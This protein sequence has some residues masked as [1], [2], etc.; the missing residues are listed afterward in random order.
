MNSFNNVSRVSF[1]VSVCLIFGYGLL[2]ATV[3]P[4][5]FGTQASESPLVTAP[6]DQPAIELA[7]QPGQPMADDRVDPRPMQ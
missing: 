3:P 4:S 6:Q 2:H 1:L 7:T 5:V